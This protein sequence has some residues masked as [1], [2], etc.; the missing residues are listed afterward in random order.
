MKND[1]P[2]VCF[3]HIW[4]NKT[5]FMTYLRGCL[6]RAWNK[7]PVKH[8][9]I[10]KKRYKIPNPNPKGRAKEVWGFT[11]EMCKNEYPINACQVDHIHPAGKLNDLED[12]QGFVERLLVVTDNDLRLVCKD[13]NSALAM[14]D[15]YGIT[16]EQAVQRKA[17]IAFKKKSLTEMNKVL[18]DLGKE[19]AKTKAEATRIY[20]S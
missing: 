1:P 11:C 7:N 9:H 5:S 19:K 13:C 17:E 16:Y 8:E 14:A 15:R 20:K 12:I 3:P 2:W 18:D 10:K 4:K 6:R